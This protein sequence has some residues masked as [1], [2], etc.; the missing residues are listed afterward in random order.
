M[1][2]IISTAFDAVGAVAGDEE[3]SPRGIVGLART[4]RGD[5][6]VD[7]HRGYQWQILR[8]GEELRKI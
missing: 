4:P 7:P 8:D 5:C 1:C 2:K 6:G 3:S